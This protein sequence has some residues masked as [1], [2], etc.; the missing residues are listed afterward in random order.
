MCFFKKEKQILY[1][2]LNEVQGAYHCI[3]IVIKL[4]IYDYQRV[5]EQA[6]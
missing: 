2:P 6:K 3:V 1:P 5:R 4:Q